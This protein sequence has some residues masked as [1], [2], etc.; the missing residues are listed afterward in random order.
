MEDSAGK[1]A[2]EKKKKNEVKI[3]Q[4]QT[5][6]VDD[7]LKPSNTNNLKEDNKIWDN[8]I[9]EDGFHPDDS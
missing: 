5:E 9:H 8:N 6:R 3:R 1:M 7:A 4:K 2:N